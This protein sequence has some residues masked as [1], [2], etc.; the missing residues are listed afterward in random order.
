[1]GNIATISADII[2]STSLERRDMEQ[3]N[4]FLKDFLFKMEEQFE[5]FW[6]RIVRGDGV[7]CV[8]ENPKDVL[9]IAAILKSWLRFYSL[10]SYKD[11][12]PAFGVR[13]SIGIG[14][15]RIVDRK[16]GIL[17]GEAIYLSGRNL[18]KMGKRYR[19]SMVFS[20]AEEGKEKLLNT[21]AYLVNTIIAK[22]SP[23]QCEVIYYKMLG[24]NEEELAERLHTTRSAVNQRS[25]GAG[26][27]AIEKALDYFEH[28][29]DL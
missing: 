9:R 2:R 18:D 27:S 6:G 15:M 28:N 22:D 24:M 3:L 17:D 4:M 25:F 13:I 21:L 16:N 20:V 14:D 11:P 26:W 7:E 5:G 19:N 29:I 23:R 1:M 10:Y 8:V 12:V